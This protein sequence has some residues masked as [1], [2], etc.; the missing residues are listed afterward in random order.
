MEGDLENINIEEKPVLDREDEEVKPDNESEDWEEVKDPSQ[1]IMDA[2][3]MKKGQQ[4]LVIVDIPNPKERWV[5][6][7]HEKKD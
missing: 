1:Q 7:E 5:K 3:V 6:P 4:K 2:K